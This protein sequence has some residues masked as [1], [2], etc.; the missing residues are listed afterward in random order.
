MKL[1]PAKCTV[2]VTSGEFL[3]YIVTQRGIE[4]NPKQITA[5]LD[6]PSPK[7]SREVQ[8]LTGRIAALTASSPCP[9]INASLSTNYH[10][11]TNV[12]SG[13]RSARRR[14][15]NSNSILRLLPCYRN[16]KPVIHSLF[17]LQYPP[18]RS[19]A[20]LSERIE[21]SRSPSSTRVS[22]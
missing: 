1:N 20:S 7:N 14:S 17:I 19:A 15:N 11:E 10:A 8:R 22:G 6:L 3:G 21:K 12:S 16:Q 13:T 9:Q 18:P 2:G 4:A 5:I